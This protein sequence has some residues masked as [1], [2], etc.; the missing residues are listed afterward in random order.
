MPLLKRL[1]A[2]IREIAM[3]LDLVVG[4]RGGREVGWSVGVADLR[5][6]SPH[7]DAT[8]GI[9]LTVAPGCGRQL[10]VSLDAREP[11]YWK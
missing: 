4:T 5:D 8:S 6:A 9:A 3:F 1:A 2:L 7:R 10:S 11:N